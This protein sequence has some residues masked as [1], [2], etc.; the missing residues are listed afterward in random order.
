[1]AASSSSAVALAAVRVDAVVLAVGAE[2]VHQRGG[3]RDRVPGGYR[4]TGVHAAQAR[5][6][7]AVHQNTVADRVAPL[8]VHRQRAGKALQRRRAAELEGLHVGRNQLFLA[9]ELLAQQLFDDLGLDVQ[10]RRQHA[11]VGDVLEQQALA[12]VGELARHQLGQRHAQEIDV[13]P[14]QLGRQWLGRVVQQVAARLHAAHVLGEG[15][16][17]HGHHQVHRTAPAGV[18][19]L[20]DADLEPGRQALDVGREDVLRAHRQ[21]HA[22]QCPRHQA[23]GAGRAGAVDVGETQYEFVDLG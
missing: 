10:Q 11:D 3:R 21:A 15:L 22:K 16:A 19:G 4:R 13:R 2:G 7:V 6:R 5:R 14:P 18:A 17:V 12:R 20:A 9:L 1:M 8:R 23:V